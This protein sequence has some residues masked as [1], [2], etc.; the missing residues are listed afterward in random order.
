MKITIQHRYLVFP[1]NKLAARKKLTFFVDGVEL[2]RLELYLDAINPDFWAYVDVSSLIGK[3][4]ELSL[5]HDMPI[6][7]READEMELPNLYAEPHRPRFDLVG[8]RLSFVLSTQS[9]PHQMGQYA[10][11]SCDLP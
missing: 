7:F 1:V 11:G 10:L 2:Y 3:E 4:L 8:W 9:L 6:T 5:S